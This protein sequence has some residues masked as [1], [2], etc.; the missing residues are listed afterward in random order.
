MEW[1]VGLH[2]GLSTSEKIAMA[3]F[4]HNWEGKS[5]SMINNLQMPT[6]QSSNLLQRSRTRFL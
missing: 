5:G 1:Q 6:I 3:E 2:G 4:Q